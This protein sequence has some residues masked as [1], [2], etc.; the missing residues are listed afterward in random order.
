MARLE[1]TDAEGRVQRVEVPEGTAGF[2]IGRSPVSNLVLPSQSVGRT[3]GRI[4]F[5]DGQFQYEDNR[6]VNGS[7]V[8]GR[9]VDPLTPVPL[10]DG[11]QIRCGDVVLRFTLTASRASSGG[12]AV[13][14]IAPEPG[15]GADAPGVEAPAAAGNDASDQAELAR[16]RRENAILRAEVQTLPDRVSRAAE[17]GPPRRDL[18]EARAVAEQE[19]Q[20]LRGLLADNER[21]VRDAEARAAMASTNLDGFHGK[22]VDLRDQVRHLQDQL[23]AARAGSSDREADA[24]QARE[25]AASLE[26]QLEAIRGRSGQAADEVAG[27]KVRLTEK[28]R[29]LERLRKELDVRE[30]DLKALEEESHRLEELCRTDTGRQGQLERKVRNLEA[31]I[32]DNRNLVEELRRGLEG[33][34]RD[35]RDARLGSGMSDL[36]HERQKLLDDYHKKSRDL[37]GARSTIAALNAEVA[38]FAREREALEARIRQLEEAAGTRRPEGEDGSGHPDSGARVRE[39]EASEAALAAAIE[40]M[41]EDLAQLGS[42]LRD[43]TA[44][45]AAGGASL[46][47]VLD[48]LR[49]VQRLITSDADR[50]RAAWA[51]VGRSTTHD[52]GH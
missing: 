5:K 30:Y 8:N 27:L 23:E 50:L 45:E 34:D 26:T 48:A 39:S 24:A 40:S 16:L 20:H 11:D 28:D 22:Y 31:V 19:V 51:Q 18:E 3:H 6:S 13:A 1:T 9:R 46:D 38:G 52:Q 49:D 36:E 15:P 2:L 21:R 42:S 44:L 47:D 33:K 35:L 7:V 43:A 17:A 4:C 14:P 10:A 41:L 25:R 32:E 29:E 37:D 12:T